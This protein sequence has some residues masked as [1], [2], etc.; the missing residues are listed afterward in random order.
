M[1]CSPHFDVE[2]NFGGLGFVAG[3]NRGREGREGGSSSCCSWMICG[4]KSA[5]VQRRSRLRMSESKTIV[6][7]VW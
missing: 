1:L 7:Q 5:R 2:V 6:S 4:V 3:P